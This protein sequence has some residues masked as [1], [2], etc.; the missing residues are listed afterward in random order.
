MPIESACDSANVTIEFL[1]IVSAVGFEPLSVKLDF[2][3]ISKL[4]S[5][6]ILISTCLVCPSP[7]SKVTI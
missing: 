7:A 6:L 1:A 4:I 2:L 5:S 3:T